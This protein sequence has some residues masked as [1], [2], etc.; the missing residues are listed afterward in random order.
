VAVHDLGGSAFQDRAAFWLRYHE[1][2]DAFIRKHFS[3]RSRTLALALH[4]HGLRLHALAARL[5]GRADEA[6]H[7]EGA[8]RALPQ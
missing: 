4:R 2:R 8:R 1:S 3:G 7:L 5:A 6:R